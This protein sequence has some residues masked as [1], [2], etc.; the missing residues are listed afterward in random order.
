MN[1]DGYA[2]AST[3]VGSRLAFRI[4]SFLVARRWVLLAIGVIL[5]AASLLPAM[6]LQFDRSLDRLFRPGDPDLAALQRIRRVFSAGDMIL[7]AYRDPG[8]AAPDA[9]GLER[10]REIVRALRAIPGVYD[11]WSLD[12]PLGDEIVDP[13]SDLAAR[14]RE[15]FEGYTHNHRGDISG[16]SVLLRPEAS[17]GRAREETVAEVRRLAASLPNGMMAGEPV[18]TVE[19]FRYIAQDGSRLG[20]VSALLLAAVIFLVTGRPRFVLVSLAVVQ[21]AV[22]GTQ[23]SMVLLKLHVSW[24]SSILTAV[25]TVVGIGAVIHILVRFQEKSRVAQTEEQALTAALAELVRPVFWVL[26]TDAIGFGAL[27]ASRVRPIQEFSWMMVLAV[28]W[29]GIA[30]A[31][32]VPGLVLFPGPRWG[33][34]RRRFLSNA[35]SRR[36]RVLDQALEA[37]LRGATRHWRISALVIAAIAVAGVIGWSRLRVETDFTRNFRRDSDVARAYGFIERELG[38]AGVWDILLPAPEHLSWPY[39]RRVQRLE[40]RLRREVIV[41]TDSGATPGLTKVLSLIDAVAAA[42]PRPLEEIRPDVVREGVIR[43]G[44]GL[45]RQRMPSLY[46][47]L[48]GP[49]PA[50]ARP[51]YWYRIMLRSQE[52]LSTAA[53]RKIIADVRRICREE[54]PKGFEG[55]PTREPVVGGYYVLLT[56]LVASVLEDQGKSLSLAILGVFVTMLIV[57]RSV[58][59][60]LASLLAN[61]LPVAAV[62]GALGWLGVP[63]NIGSAMMAAVALGLSVDGTIHYLF[64]RDAAL[65]SGRTYGEALRAAQSVVGPA[66]VLA[67]L[68]LTA[69]FA[70]MILSELIPTVHFGLLLSLTMLGGMLSNLYVLPWMLALSDRLKRRKCPE[71]RRLAPV[72]SSPAADELLGAP[73]ITEESGIRR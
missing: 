46:E 40:D 33:V 4:A 22:F 56:R 32:F 26:V 29:V 24:V 73:A 10:L 37:L 31:L 38:G 68:A 67:T 61:L 5:L 59:T 25:I 51:V 72:E 71:A 21:V 20:W 43:V 48:Y 27:G 49:D 7:V 52:R 64:V 30:A 54:F 1:R 15:L 63:A 12:Q 66:A 35:E 16:L 14:M 17:M 60:A 65:R 45:I 18:L 23:A 44:M 36:T 28:V 57:S 11:V 13:H 6:R 62:L 55:D 19:G 41:P 34:S 8:L 50:A 58:V 42:A 70:T 3:S 47:A 39:L 69:G 2:L 9:S 53:K